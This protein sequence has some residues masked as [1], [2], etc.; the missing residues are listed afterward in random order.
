[1]STPFFN[2]TL[3]YPG[4]LQEPSF[5]DLT[6]SNNS[7]FPPGTVLD[8]WCLDKS[9][10]FGTDTAYTGY[11]YSAYEPPTIGSILPNLSAAVD[12]LDSV[13]WLLNYYNGSDV[14][15]N[16]GEVQS[17]I[18]SLMGQDYRTELGYTQEGGVVLD[19]DVTSL[20][21]QALAHDGYRPGLGESIAMI[22]DPVDAYG[23]ATATTSWC[24]W[25]TTATANSQAPS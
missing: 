19:A 15:Y 12:R 22:V 25:M 3:S 10:N 2:F 23:M 7:L 14:R 4:N 16:W 6:V 8:A 24:C 11:V 17:A 1:M 5:L 20:V 18:W 13:N 9:I 21:N